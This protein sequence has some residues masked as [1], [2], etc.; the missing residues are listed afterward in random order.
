MSCSSCCE[1]CFAC[2]TAYL[3]YCCTDTHYEKVLIFICLISNNQLKIDFLFIKCLKKVAKFIVEQNE[4]VYVPRGLLIIDPIERGLRVV[5]ETL[6]FII[7]G[8][9]IS[10]RFPLQIEICIFS[11]NPASTPVRSNWNNHSDIF[12]SIYICILLYSTVY[13]CFV[14]PHPYVQVYFLL[15]IV[16]SRTFKVNK[17]SSSI[18]GFYSYTIIL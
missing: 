1:G 10:C 6:H 11:D 17:C 14:C 7:I 13:L 5:S 16:S 3:L 12:V 8:H 2:L 15:L 4:R 9:Y 18:S